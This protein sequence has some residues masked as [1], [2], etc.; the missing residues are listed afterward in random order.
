MKSDSGVFPSP[1][2]AVVPRFCERIFLGSERLILLWLFCLSEG[3]SFPKWP[4]T[5]AG[6]GLNCRDNS[7]GLKWQALLL[8]TSAATFLE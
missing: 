6:Q 2:R 7:D 3:K 1:K 4:A 5:S 8:G